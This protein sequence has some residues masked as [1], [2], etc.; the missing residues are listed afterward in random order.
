M[1]VVWWWLK[2]TLQD[3]PKL[4]AASTRE[5]SEEIARCADC[6]A[7]ETKEFLKVGHALTLRPA[8]TSEL[9]SRFSGNT[10]SVG[11][12]PVRFRFWE[13]EGSLWGANETSGRST[14]VTWMFGSGHHG[15]TPVIVTRN[16]QGE[17]VNSD[18]HVTWYQPHGL[19]LTIG[20]E[21]GL[22][23]D[24]H[25]L[26]ASNSVTDTRRC[27]DCH[28]TEL[29]RQGDAV[30]TSHLLPGV[31]CSKCHPNARQHAEQMA[32]G[33]SVAKFDD[34]KSLTPQQSVDRCGECH[35]SPTALQPEELKPENRRLVRFASVGLSLS[36]CFQLQHTKPEDNGNVR[37][38]DCITCH[39]PHKPTP[40]NLEHYNHR[41]RE[42]H[43][44][45]NSTESDCPQQSLQSDCVSC[46]M[47]KVRMSA[48]VSFTD[49]WIRAR[50]EPQ[51]APATQK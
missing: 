48:P 2:P 34:W 33:D 21:S 37:R 46:H 26:G 9:R 10:V 43:A 42:C 5:P 45:N 6:H 30:E 35:R 40:D 1:A 31:L 29:P 18:L 23:K 4:V 27:F 32:A 17:E 50:P 19:A 28:T 36:H 14:E 39:D 22:A 25:S 3:S 7:A 49:H 20:H 16:S 47:P 44:R 38:L 41:C 13:Q 24:P 8:H 51:V 11:T 12:P 15:V